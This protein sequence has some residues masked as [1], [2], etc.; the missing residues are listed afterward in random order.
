LRERLSGGEPLCRNP[1]S[2]FSFMRAGAGGVMLFV[3]GQCFECAEETA[4]FAEMLCAQVRFSVAAD[5]TGSDAAMALIA[6]LV[7]MGSI[8]F[9]DADED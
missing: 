3:D 1:A 8:A 2:R 7:N 4:T 9:E 5:V 6:Q